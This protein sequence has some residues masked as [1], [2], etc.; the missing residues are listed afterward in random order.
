[1]GEG[2]I[3]GQTAGNPTIIRTL[4]IRIVSTIGLVFNPGLLD[5]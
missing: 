2:M 1:M 4:V 3:V 5:H